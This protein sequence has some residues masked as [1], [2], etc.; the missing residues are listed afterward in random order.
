MIQKRDKERENEKKTHLKR[1]R[2]IVYLEN[3]IEELEK[4]VHSMKRETHFCLNCRHRSPDFYKERMS[5]IIFPEVA[6]PSVAGPL[7]K[8]SSHEGHEGWLEFEKIDF[9]GPLMQTQEME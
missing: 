6:T 2:R 7:T 4:E 1:K 3:R 8:T 5:E 9:H